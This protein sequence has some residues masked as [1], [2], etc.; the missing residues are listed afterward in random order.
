MSR[1]TLLDGD[2]WRKAFDRLDIG[3]PHLLEEL[4]GIGSESDVYLPLGVVF[5]L[6]LGVDLTEHHLLIEVELFSW[7]SAHVHQ[8]VLQLENQSL[9]F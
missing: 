8:S 7:S 4:S 2:R 6:S 9:F 3:F 5:L 1:P